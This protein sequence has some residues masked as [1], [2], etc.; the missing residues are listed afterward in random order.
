MRTRKPV[1]IVSSILCSA[2]LCAL[3]GTPAAASSG[4][5]VIFTVDV[6]SNGAFRLPDQ[7]D[8]VCSDGSRCG[9]MTIVRMLEERTWP[10]TFFLNVYE[11]REW[12]EPLMRDLTRKLQDAGQDLALHT[13]PQHAYD[14]TRPGMREYSLE[15][16][17][18][19][20]RDGVQ[21]LQSWTGLPVVAHRAGAYA[22]DERTLRALERNGVLID[23]SVFWKHP[24]SRL[25]ALGLPR[26]LPARYGQVL[27]IPVTV[28]LRED[29]PKLA[30]SIVA[31]VSVVRKLDAD[32]FS[33]A[34]EMRS[35][36]D[37][38][39][40]A[41]LPV[42]VVFLHSFSFMKTGADGKPVPN[43]Q[44]I[45]MFRAMLDHLG[46]RNVPVV[47]MRE[48]AVRDL[49]IPSRGTDVVPSVTVRVDLLR[50]VWRRMKYTDDASSVG[51]GGG[52]ALVCAGAALVV[53]RQRRATGRKRRAMP[54]EAPSR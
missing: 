29:R 14:H 38:S 51:L 46:H 37:A 1:R 27:Q 34:A 16:Q 28:Y 21:L 5:V 39:I 36:I 19:I 6:E 15:E 8:P 45:E 2:V 9:L 49:P 41:D 31:P 52:I 54:G 35:A 12:G 7:I 4:P 44:S 47:T 18:E 30:G 11:H 26:N 33:N 42:L 24:N 48:L 3:L 13:H 17:T 50:Y 23:S 53:A 10:A 25:D 22:A 20:V 32:W 40:A 43:R